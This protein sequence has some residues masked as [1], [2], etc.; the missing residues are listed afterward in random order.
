VYGSGLLTRVQWL[1][2]IYSYPDLLEPGRT[3]AKYLQPLY[4][5]LSS[6]VRAND[7]Q[8]L[9][10][11]EP[12]VVISQVRRCQRMCREGLTPAS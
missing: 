9:V 3:D 6:V 7:P 4:D 2:D 1:G 11:Y 8:R 12:A 10:F 5:R